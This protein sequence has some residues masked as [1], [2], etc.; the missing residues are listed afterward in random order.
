MKKLIIIIFVFMLLVHIIGQYGGAHQEEVDEPQM[1]EKLP[2]LWRR[3]AFY[4]PLYLKFTRRSRD[5]KDFNKEDLFNYLYSGIPTQTLLLNTKPIKKV[6]EK[7]GV[8]EPVTLEL[9]TKNDSRMAQLGKF[10]PDKKKG[11]LVFYIFRNVPVTFMKKDLKK[12]LDF[13][14]KNDLPLDSPEECMLIFKD[15][16]DKVIAKVQAWCYFPLKYKFPQNEKLD[17]FLIKGLYDEAEEYC[18][19]QNEKI[20]KQCQRRLGDIYFEE[21]N[22][23]KAVLYYEMTAYK[24]GFDKIGLVYLE[25]GD[26]VE[27]VKYFARGTH[28]ADRARAYAGLADYYRTEESNPE[29]AKKYYTKAIDEYEYLIKDYYYVWNQTDSDQ[30]RRCIRE[31][32]LLPKSHEESARQKRLRRILEKASAY[33]E[34]LYNNFFHFFC[35]EVITEYNR[36]SPYIT[37]DPYRHS[38]VGLTTTTTHK[39]INTH[40]Y[41]Y[42]YQLI[43]ENKEAVEWRTLLEVDGIRRNIKNAQLITRHQYE[44]LIFGPI[45]FLSKFWQD[46]YDYKILREDSLMG[47]RVVVIEAIPKAAKQV[48]QLVGNIWI[49]EDE[50]SGFD[51][52]KLEWNPKAMLENFEDILRRE[53]GLNA[54]LSY[55]FFAEFNIKREG[56]RLPSRY[57]IEEAYI[58]EEDKKKNVHARTEVIFKDHRYFKVSTEVIKSEGKIK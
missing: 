4:S 55:T 15:A 45:A 18:A 46:Y 7:A 56:F 47:E 16:S 42:E 44:K 2:E 11:K 28:S 22:F 5:V 57:F 23:A 49:K 43:R 30:R 1:K 27:A 21:G 8:L 51:I 31:R 17:R 26:Y 41:I 38:N 10:T 37:L 19:G 52:L 53:Q 54:K 12:M 34:R 13:K 33:C 40:K 6:L 25:E 14:L 50:N 20:R 36:Q 29:L 48:N 32:K 3:L 58:R 24:K 35:R 39:Y 9:F